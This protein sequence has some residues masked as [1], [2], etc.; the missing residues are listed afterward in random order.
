MLNLNMNNN[1]IKLMIFIS[2]VYS[3]HIPSDERGDPNYRRQTNIDVNKVRATTFN[4]G[5]VGR[6]GNVPGEI[7]FEWPANSGHH[8]IAMKAFSVGSLI[9][10]SS[11]LYK[12][13]ITIPFR[14]DNNGNSKGWEPIPEYLNS[15][16]PKIATNND[17]I[18]WPSCWNDKYNELENP[19]WCGSWNSYFGENYFIEGKEIYT[20]FSDDRN[21][22]EGYTY[23]PDTTDFTR[24]GAGLLVEQRTIGWDLPELEDVIFN[25]YTIKN[26]G[27]KDLEQNSLAIWIAD[28]IG[29]DGDDDV[30]EYDLINQ[31]VWFYDMDGIGSWGNQ[32]EPG[33]VGFLILETPD[34]NGITSINFGQAEMIPINNDEYFWNTFMQPGSFNIPV[35]P[36][37]N[38]IMIS[39]G[40]FSLEPGQK[41]DLISAIFL[42]N[43]LNDLYDKAEYIRTF[44]EGGF[45]LN[46]QQYAIINITPEFGFV[47]ADDGITSDLI[48]IELL[49][50]FDNSI[51]EID[52]MIEIEQTSDIFWLTTDE[53]GI[54]S[55][56]FSISL[57]PENNI[58]NIYATASNPDINIET[59]EIIIDVLPPIEYN[60]PNL[61]IPYNLD[62]INSNDSINLYWFNKDT[63]NIFK[64]YKNNMLIEQLDFE[65]IPIGHWSNNLLW[66]FKFDNHDPYSMGD[67]LSGHYKVIFTDNQQET[68][69]YCSDWLN[70]SL[71]PCSEN[72]PSAWCSTI[73]Y[74][75]KSLNVKVE[76]Q[77]YS[78]IEDDFIWQEIP[79]AFGDYSPFNTDTQSSNPDGIFNADW[80]ETDYLIFLDSEEDGNT[81]QTWSFTLDYPGS[82]SELANCCNEPQPGDTAYVS[83]PYNYIDLNPENGEICYNVTNYMPYTESEHSA[84]VCIDYCNTVID[85]CDVCGGDNSSCSLQGDTNFDGIVDILDIVRIVNNIMGNSEFNDDEFTAADFNA[86]GIV[87]ILDIVQIVNYILP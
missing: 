49:D 16:S 73:L 36:G 60:D 43:D 65:P 55:F 63:N 69:C 22:L 24:G 3:T 57:M 51:P 54:C 77:V 18:S 50:Y 44:Y 82:S 32:P 61:S 13:L 74:E 81:K 56:E 14:T 48:T 17:Y 66:D 76:K 26:D 4:Y 62:I 11:D 8:Y 79:F 40:F 15:S 7:P 87:D 37:D 23:I 25:I 5:L 28:Y 27:T 6:T 19:G 41:K 84:E 30:I 52:V 10:V 78:E 31:M 35:I 34:D 85:E 67:A 71:D 1:L 33:S 29:G 59:D 75:S 58:V 20:K 83:T 9:E 2:L 46:P 47:H 12:P 21:S 86:D 53:A 45:S 68:E 70:P 38:D 80:H 42:G 64:L 39:S 72:A